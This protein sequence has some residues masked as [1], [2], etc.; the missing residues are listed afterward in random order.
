VSAVGEVAVLM[1][2]TRHGGSRGG[3]SLPVHLKHF[4]GVVGWRAPTVVGS[5][6][7]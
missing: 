1:L 4:C 6:Q 7:E 3:Q 2:K 5:V